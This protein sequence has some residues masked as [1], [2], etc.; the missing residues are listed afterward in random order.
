MPNPNNSGKAIAEQ[1]KKEVSENRKVY[2]WGTDARYTQD[3]PGFVEAKD[4]HSLPKDVQLTD[5]VAL[6]L[7][8][9]DAEG[10]ENLG[11]I[12]IFGIFESWDSLKDFRKLITPAIPSGLPI[13]AEYWR[14]DAWFGAQFLNASNPDLIKKCEKLPH[15]FQVENETVEK[16]LDRGYNLNKAIG[17]IISYRCYKSFIKRKIIHIGKLL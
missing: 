17:V 8:E 10:F 14:D 15:N 5:E 16:L 3:L 2:K 1:R 11:L 7:L 12:D 6:P 4:R 9:A 13:A